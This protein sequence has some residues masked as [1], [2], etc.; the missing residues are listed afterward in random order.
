[1]QSCKVGSHEGQSDLLI[2]KIVF[3]RRIQSKPAARSL[4]DSEAS[5]HSDL[6]TIQFIFMISFSTTAPP[7][8]GC[9][10]LDQPS[11]GEGRVYTPNKLAVY[12]RATQKD[13]HPFTLTQTP[14][15]TL[16]VPDNL[17]RMFLEEAGAPAENPHTHMQ[18]PVTFSL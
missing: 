8:R 16:G 15:A 17:T 6:L 10:S 11:S 4:R 7:G 5:G 2:N 12:S 18:T 13:K 1:M 9:C 14:T 3:L